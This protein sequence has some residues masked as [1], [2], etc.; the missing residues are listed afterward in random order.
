[1]TA[2]QSKLKTCLEGLVFGLAFI[3]G[4]TRSGYEYSCT[5]EDSILTDDEARRSIDRQ[6][7][8]MGAMQL[9]EYRAKWYGEDEATAKKAV[10]AATDG[11]AE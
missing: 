5:F 11:V 3:N 6:E 2:I 9:W 10:E 8:A 7:V 1:M 4:L